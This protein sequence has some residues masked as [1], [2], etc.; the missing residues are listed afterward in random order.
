MEKKVDFE[1]MFQD[2]EGIVKKM[3]EGNL[4]LADSLELFERGI[5]LS[6]TLRA[7]LDAVENRVEMLMKNADGEGEA[8]TP[9]L[10]Q[11]EK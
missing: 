5:S 2:L 4:P 3:E 11:E 7:E 1:K 6:R 10:L 9:F 8:T